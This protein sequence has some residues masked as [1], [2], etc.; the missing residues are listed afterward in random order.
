[1][2]AE[3]VR[4]QPP[5]KTVKSN[6]LILHCPLCPGDILTMT[7]AIEAL[8]TQ[9]HGQYLTDV[10]TPCNAIFEN[11][12]NITQLHGQGE[13]VSM[14]YTDSI[15]QS[16]QVNLH[17]IEGYTRFLAGY[18][19]I[20]LTPLNRP[21][22]YVSDQEKSW[23]NQVEEE[24]GYK[25]PYWALCCQGK[26]DY[27]VKHYVYEYVQ[28][29]IDHYRGVIQ[30]V[31]VGRKEHNHKPHEGVI[32]FIGKTDDR[33]LI[34]L[35]YNSAGG[36]GLESYLHHLYA[37]FEKP[38]VCISSGMTARSW[39]AY[40]TEKY[41]TSLSNLPC[42]K[43]GGCWKKKIVKTN[44]EQCCEYPVFNV[45]IEPVAKC[46]SMIKPEEIIQAIDSYYLGGRLSY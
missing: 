26:E 28:D 12:P 16:N 44:G 46:M 31:Q 35:C 30:F 32:N 40:N 22:L 34:R 43:N 6:Q 9:Y 4:R 20:T 15:N 24:T 14:E 17:F 29:V 45:G 27:T 8:H 41:L 36:L 5:V 42:C 23:I 21:Y 13:R 7:A 11:N 3:K 38:F 39:Q 2:A 19:G 25:G 18:L 33:Q 37:G 1:M 10:D